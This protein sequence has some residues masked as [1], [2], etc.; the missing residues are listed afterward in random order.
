MSGIHLL[1]NELLSVIRKEMAADVWQQMSPCS[2][3]EVHESTLPYIW[4]LKMKTHS[5]FS[6]ILT[7]SHIILTGI[8]VV[9][10]I[11]V[12]C[13]YSCIVCNTCIVTVL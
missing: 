8:Y 12:T 4:L 1:A 5:T 10:S 7:R 2:T 9:H 11:V 6:L 3:V 13:S